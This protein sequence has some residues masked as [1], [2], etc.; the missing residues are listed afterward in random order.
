MKK[1][2]F[3][4][5]AATLIVLAAIGLLVYNV[6]SAPSVNIIQKPGVETPTTPSGPENPFDQNVGPQIGNN[7]NNTESTNPSNDDNENNGETDNP[8]ETTEPKPT[9]P[10]VVTNQYKFSGMMFEPNEK[11]W[12]NHAVIDRYL[13]RSNTLADWWQNKYFS[14]PDEETMYEDLGWLFDIED[15]RVMKWNDFQHQKIKDLCV[16]NGYCAIFVVEGEITPY[17]QAVVVTA[18][19]PQMTVGEALAKGEWMYSIR[20]IGKMDEMCEL[21][22]GAS[23]VKYASQLV[24]TW[25]IPSK[26]YYKKLDDWTYNYAFEY[27]LSDC[28]VILYGNEVPNYMSVEEDR[29]NP[30]GLLQNL[31]IYGKGTGAEDAMAYE[32]EDYKEFIK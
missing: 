30:R 25:G 29:D 10:P 20:N 32:L 7:G 26:T 2:R 19:D 17:E 1:E 11:T 21:L 18:Q 3:L 16:V 24:S 23:E 12:E 15:E 14:S 28:T 22:F 6:L 8:G 9:I 31:T 4:L 13:P 5:I 27:R